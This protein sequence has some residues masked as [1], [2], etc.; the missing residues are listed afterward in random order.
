MV[1]RSMQK[2]GNAEPIQGAF[3]PTDGVRY[4]FSASD[5]DS[6]W[7]EVVG[8]EQEAF[9]HR[10]I[11]CRAGSV[12]VV[13]RESEPVSDRQM[14]LDSNDSSFYVI[15]RGQRVWMK[16]F[17]TQACQAIVMPHEV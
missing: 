11:K 3:Q 7:H 13:F 9:S 4:D 1:R 5:S 2:D 6:D 15:R 8:P 17:G 12:M 16:R 14:I 10:Y